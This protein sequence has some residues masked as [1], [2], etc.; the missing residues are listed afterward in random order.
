MTAKVRTIR[1][2]A[3]PSVVLW[4]HLL[5]SREAEAISTFE[6]S[7]FSLP[8]MMLLHLAGNTALHIALTMKE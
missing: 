2:K 6:N 8:V 1:Q 5:V 4:H 3:V 7:F